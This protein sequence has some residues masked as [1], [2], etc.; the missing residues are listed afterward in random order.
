MTPKAIANMCGDEEFISSSQ[1]ALVQTVEIMHDGGQCK[2]RCD[3][4]EMPAGV[5]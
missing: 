2:R 5:I 4:A 3:I 1:R